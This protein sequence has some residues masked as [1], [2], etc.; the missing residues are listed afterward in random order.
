MIKVE[1]FRNCSRKIYGFKIENHGDPIVC[2]AVSALSINTVNSIKTFTTDKVNVNYDE[3]GGF[4]KFE[5]PVFIDNCESPDAELLLNSLALGLVEIEKEYPKHI[6]I[7]DER[8][9]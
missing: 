9:R 4:V 8:K 2:A 1:I 3:N 6:K 5:L 7:N